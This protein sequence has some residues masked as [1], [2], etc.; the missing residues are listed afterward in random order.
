MAEIVSAIRSGKT[1]TNVN[2][3]NDIKKLRTLDN[4][5]TQKVV[6]A[7]LP[8]VTFGGEF[9]EIG[10]EYL[11]KYS[12]FIIID[13]DPY[14]KIKGEVVTVNPSLIESYD[15][16]RARVAA[17]KYTHVCFTSPG[18]KGIKIVVKITDQPQ[19]IAAIAREKFHNR[20]FLFLEKYYLEKYSLVVD[21]SGKD[22]PRRCF[23]SH[24]PDI[25]FNPD[26]PVYLPE[27]LPEDTAD[28]AGAGSPLDSTGTPAGDASY[29]PQIKKLPSGEFAYLVP[30]AQKEENWNAEKTRWFHRIIQIAGKV[31]ENEIDMTGDY[32]AE[33]LGI[34][35]SLAIF[36]ETGRALFHLFSKFHAEYSP[37]K[38][39][40]KFSNLLKKH[41]FT[42]PAKLFS[43]ARDYGV[44]SD[45]TG[46]PAAAAHTGKPAVTDHS[47]GNTGD[48]EANPFEKLIYSDVEKQIFEGPFWHK[49][50]KLGINGRIEDVTV[51]FI[52]QGMKT[53]LTDKGFCRLKIS[54]KAGAYSSQFVRV[55]DKVVTLLENEESDK[56]EKIMSDFIFEWMEKNNIDPEVQEA[57]MRGS[58]QYFTK[59]KFERLPAREFN[60]KADTKTESFLFFKNCFVKTSSEQEIFTY[61]KLDCFI[62]QSQII[63]HDFTYTD[64][65]GKS[66][67]FRFLMLGI[68]EKEEFTDSDLDK[69]LLQK[70]LSFATAIGYMLHGYKKY[71]KEIATCIFDK[72]VKDENSEGGTGKSIVFKALGK[73][74]PVVIIDGQNFDITK[75]DCFSEVS[76][77]TSIIIINDVKKKFDF[78]KFFHLITEG[79]RVKRLYV[80][81]V[82]IT[83]ENSPKWGFTGNKPFS[84][85]GK[86]FERRQFILEFSPFWNKQ[87]PLDFFGH[88]LMRNDWDKNQWDMFYSFHIQCI[89]KYMQYGL[90]EMPEAEYYLNKLLSEVHQSFVE[91]CNENIVLDQE[92]KKLELFDQYKNWMK[93]IDQLDLA[94][95]KTN[96]FTQ[97]LQ[98]WAHYMH[99]GINIHKPDGRDRR[100]SVDYITIKK[101]PKS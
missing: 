80:N 83:Y 36:G 70:I 30:P 2:F 93:D 52:N 35:C 50:I 41:K 23:L 29:D 75:S 67:Y 77:D 58:H 21:P 73:L 66:E 55:N 37:A 59:Q 56:P 4:E 6:K 68:T 13:F 62:W 98:K 24:D 16:I 44:V 14:Q 32:S 51:K 39:D 99:Y 61:D 86:S 7:G 84:G 76:L 48:S 15:S 78:T 38:T 25:F 60:F 91:W 20:W 12:G 5:A 9:K 95:M 8:W 49:T 96:T 28:S 92:Y 101:L 46:Q 63:D 34:G 19:S 53:W 3:G 79:I 97:Y 47:N 27:F 42:T 43:I 94:G 45:S 89:K 1:P 57:M 65:I 10:L 90:S 100:N 81:P 72:K 18:G 40:A 22:I 31:Q 74:K 85:H 54:K 87:S 88:E 64:D 69:V 33:W 71:G 82:S 26:S 11:T 17:D